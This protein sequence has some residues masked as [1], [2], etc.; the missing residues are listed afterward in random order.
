MSYPKIFKVALD[1][2]LKWEGGYVHHPKDPGGPTKYGITQKTYDE[3]R[4][5][6]GLPEKRV[7]KLTFEEAEKIYFF[8]YWTE[9]ARLTEQVW[10]EF[11]VALFD[12]F[13]QFGIQGGTMLWQQALGI[14]VDGIWGPI[15]DAVTKTYINKNGITESALALVGER[16]KY[17]GKRVKEAAG[18]VVFL[19]GWL[20]RDVDLM[21]YVLKIFRQALELQ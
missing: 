2:T 5:R 7:A 1:F 6:L 8:R 3:C 10:F 19:Q 20:N 9:V 14:R 11:K 18:Q 17:R 16:I 4:K 15:T 12:T 13:V 21:L